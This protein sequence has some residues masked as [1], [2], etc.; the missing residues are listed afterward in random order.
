MPRLHPRPNPG[1]EL[2]KLE[3]VSN[4]GSITTEAVLTDL[5]N[6]TVTFGVRPVMIHVYL[7]LVT[8]DTAARN[9]QAKLYEVTGAATQRAIGN[10]WSVNTGTGGSIHLWYPVAAQTPGTVQTFEVRAVAPGGGTATVVASA[11]GKAFI[12]ANEV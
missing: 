4:Q 10:V 1:T 12:R 8:N 3:M 7:P 2:N 5:D 11:T 9:N 6:F